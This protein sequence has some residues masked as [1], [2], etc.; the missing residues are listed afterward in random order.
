MF[1]NGRIIDTPCSSSTRVSERVYVYI[2]IYISKSMKYAKR[3]TYKFIIHQDANISS[4]RCN[5]ARLN[6]TDSISPNNAIKHSFP[7]GLCF[8]F[9]HLRRYV[10]IDELVCWIF[11]QIFIGVPQKTR[12]KCK[13]F[14]E[15]LADRNIRG[16]PILFCVF[17][18]DS[19]N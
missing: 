8:P 14:W 2:H 19:E 18:G 4:V 12:G 11:L 7:F 9:I 17:D 16:F 15:N 5:F 6:E 1:N 13:E 10:C 3:K